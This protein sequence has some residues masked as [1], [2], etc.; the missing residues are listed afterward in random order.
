MVT[1]IGGVIVL[2]R[3]QEDSDGYVLDITDRFLFSIVT[4]ILTVYAYLWLSENLK[5]EREIRNQL[6][7]IFIQDLKYSQISEIRPDYAKF[8]YS[9]VIILLGIT[10]LMAIWLDILK[11]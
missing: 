8:G 2:S 11:G 7:E 4:F 6:D 1:I 10:A 5:F 3:T 9:V